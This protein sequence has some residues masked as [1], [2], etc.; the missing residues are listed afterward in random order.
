MHLCVY[1]FLE[2]AWQEIHVYAV[3][4]SVRPSACLSV[5]VCERVAILVLGLLHF[6]CDDAAALADVNVAETMNYE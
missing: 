1:L 5:Y 4:P 2:I 3:C 6:R